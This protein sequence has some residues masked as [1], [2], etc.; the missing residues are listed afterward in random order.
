MS[1]HSH[2][3][4]PAPRP[5]HARPEQCRRDGWTLDRQIAFIRALHETGCVA[6]AAAGMGREGAYRLRA[7]PGHAAFAA[8]WD[9]ALGAVPAAIFRP[10]ESHSRSAGSH[11]AQR[12]RRPLSPHESHEGH[13]TRQTAPQRQPSQLFQP[14]GA[15]NR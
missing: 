5:S 1:N 4:S 9:R 15:P 11:A 6:R 3:P 10:R 13:S 14:A 2:D 8:A 12:P 7:R